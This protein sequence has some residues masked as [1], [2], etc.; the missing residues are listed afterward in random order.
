MYIHLGKNCLEEFDVTNSGLSPSQISVSSIY[1]N[2]PSLFGPAAS[3]LG[4]STGWRP[5]SNTMHESIMVI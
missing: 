1:N 3:G 4:S 5:A 2:Q